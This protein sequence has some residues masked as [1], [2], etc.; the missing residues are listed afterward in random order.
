LA[1]DCP[2]FHLSFFQAITPAVSSYVVARKALGL[3]SNSPSD[4][5]S[6][7]QLRRPPNQPTEA[8]ATPLAAVGLIEP[9]SLAL[10]EPRCCF[11]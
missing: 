5:L 11:S 9:T 10:L 6:R 1:A 3:P 7:F 8:A 4:P 2:L